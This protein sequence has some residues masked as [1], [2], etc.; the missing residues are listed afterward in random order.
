MTK[1]TSKDA[2]WDTLTVTLM[3]VLWARALCVKFISAVYRLFFHA[4]LLVKLSCMLETFNFISFLWL[5]KHFFFLASKYHMFRHY[6]LSMSQIKFRSG[7]AE[8]DASTFFYSHLTVCRRDGNPSWEKQRK[9]RVHDVT[10]F[11]WI[12]L[13]KLFQIQL[14]NFPSFPFPDWTILRYDTGSR[15][16]FFL[17][18]NVWRAF[19]EPFTVFAYF[20]FIYHHDCKSEIQFCVKQFPTISMSKGSNNKGNERAETEN[21]KYWIGK[22]TWK[23]REK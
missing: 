5:A 7:W 15:L 22:G 23:S 1:F 19:P 6:K 17:F 21:K 2:V 8:S 4:F 11:T 13:K 3:P 14:R 20:H 16:F 12:H 9:K 10:A 18:A